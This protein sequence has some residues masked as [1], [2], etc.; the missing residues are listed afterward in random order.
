MRDQ[1]PGLRLLL[2]ALGFRA[3]ECFLEQVLSRL[4]YRLLSLSAVARFDKAAREQ[5]LQLCYYARAGNFS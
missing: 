4:R 1:K 5:R 3:Y 2:S